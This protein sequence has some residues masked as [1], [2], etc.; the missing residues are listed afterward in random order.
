MPS[1]S[2]KSKSFLC[3]CSFIEI[4][5]EQIYDLLGSP[6]ASSA[7]IYNEQIYDLLDSAYASLFLRENIKKGVFVEGAMEKIVTSAAEA[8]QVLSMGWRNRRVASTSMNRESSRSHAVFTMEL[9]SKETVNEV[10]NIR[11]SQLNLD[12]LGGNAKTYIIANAMINED[13][14][15]N[16]RQ[17]QAEVKKL[18]EQLAQ[19]L[20]SPS[21]MMLSG[22]DV[23]PGG[24][25]PST[26]PSNYH[27]EASYKTKFLQAIDLWKKGGKEKMLLLQ[28][29][30]QLEEAWAQKEKFIHSSRMIVK[31][32]ED[33]ISLY[34]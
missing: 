8:Y 15:G 7:S 23:A 29:V 27:P 21:S 28:K 33:H 13:T 14:Q 31:F 32:R 19:L 12:S 3:K 5:N 11:T 20:T 30:A 18:K 6:R 24:P 22:R 2:G 1:E 34:Q 16:M 25:Q 26:S 4:Y 17:L 10:V 9:E